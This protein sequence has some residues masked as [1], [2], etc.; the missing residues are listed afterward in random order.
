MKKFLWVAAIVGLMT[1]AAIGQTAPTGITYTNTTQTPAQLAVITTMVPTVTGSPTAPLTYTVASGSLPA[2]VALN[3]NTGYIG[4]AAMVAGTFTSTITVS[5]SAGSVTSGTIS[6]TV[7]SDGTYTSGSWSNSLLYAMNPGATGITANVANFPVLLRLNSANNSAIFSS[8]TSPNDLRFAR[9]SNTNVHYPYQIEQWNKTLQQAV[10][11]VLVDTVFSGST[12]QGITMYWGNSGAAADS[13]GKAVF[14]IGNGFAAVWHL[15]NNLTT[16]NFPG[17]SDATGN[18]Y[19]LTAHGTTH[20]DAGII[21]SAAAF[22]GASSSYLSNASVL[23]SPTVVTLSTWVAD[24]ETSGEQDFLSLDNSPTLTTTVGGGSDMFYEYSGGWYGCGSTPLTTSWTYVTAVVNPT[25]AGGG[26]A[27]E[28][29]YQ[30]G[31][32]IGT[33][34]YTAAIDYAGAATWLG[35]NEASGNTGRFLKGPMNEARVENVP[36]S[37]NWI[38]LNYINQLPAQT[39]IQPLLVPSAP[40]LS[41]PSNSAANQAVTLTL[42]WASSFGATPTSYQVQLATSSTFSTASMVADDSAITSTSQTVGSPTTLLNATYYFW[43]ALAINA[44][45]LS[46]WS[47][48]WSFSTITLWGPPPLFSPATG[49]IN[50][51]LTPTLSWVAVTNAASYEIQIST[52]PAFGSVVQDTGGIA[53]ISLTIP[54]GTGLSNY[55]TYYWRANA[56]DPNSGSDGDSPNPSNWSNA[57][58]FTTVIAVPLLSTPTNGAANQPLSS[59]GLSWGTVFNAVS[60]TLNVST[61]STFAS[62]VYN[63]SVSGTSQTL[64]N[65]LGTLQTYYWEVSATGG[66]SG[67]GPWST[68]WSFSTIPPPPGAPTIVWPENG[69]S[70]IPLSPNLTWNTVV[71]AASYEMQMATASGFSATTFDQPGITAAVYNPGPLQFLTT[72]YWEVRATNAGGS[73]PW[74]SVLSFTSCENYAANWTYS[75]NIPLT[76]LA[77]ATIGNNVT[78]FP[79]LIRFN[80]ANFPLMRTQ[81]QSGGADIRFSSGADPT[82]AYPFQ[83]D[84]WSPTNDTA[85]IWVLVDTIFAGNASHSITL[86]YGNASAPGASYGPQVFDTTNGFLGVW[87]LGVNNYSDATANGRTATPTSTITD[88]IGIIGHASKFKIPN[89]DSIKVVGLMGSP[90]MVTL[91]CWAKVDSI[92]TTSG[93][94]SDLMSIGDC[95][96][97]RVTATNATNPVGSGRD[98]AL[99]F[100]RNSAAIWPNFYQTTGV[101]TNVVYH[102]G[103]KNFAVE[104]NPSGSNPKEQV[105]LNGALV[106]TGDSAS[107]ISYSGDGV[108]TIFGRN[109]GGAK[110]FFGGVMNEP[111]IDKVIRSIDWLNLCFQNQQANQT[112]VVLAALPSIPTLASPANNA[113]GQ[114]TAL[115]LN[116]NSVSGALTYEVQV[117]TAAGFGVATVS[118][119]AGLTGVSATVAGLAGSTTYY[120]QVNATNGAGTTAWS[121]AWSFTTTIGSPALSSPANGATGQP[122]TLSL[123]WGSVSG[124]V[125]YGV[126]VST[127]MSF[128]STVSGQTGLTGLYGVVTSL[129]GGVTYYWEA[130]ATGAAATGAWSGVWSFSAG[131]TQVIP[132]NTAWNM[133]SLNVIPLQDTTTMVFGTDPGGF[134]FV[135]D[136]AGDVYCPA[137]YQDN[138]NYVQVGQG[139]QVYTTVP[140]TMEVMGIPVNYAATAIALSSGWNTIAY[141]P[142][143]DDSIEHALA[144]IDTLLI[145]V[146]N[147]SGH[148]Y[149]PSLGIDDIGIMYVGE[150]YKV[151][152]S[153]AASLTYPTPDTGVAKRVA[154]RGGKTMLRLPE[155]RHYATHANTGNN[156]TLLAK[157]VTIGD[158]AVPDSS[159]IGAFDGTGSLVGSGTV[160]HGIAAF[161]VWGIDPQGKTKKKDG[162]AVSESV[163]FRL[164]DGKREYPLDY[165]TQNGTPAKYGVDKVFLGVLSVPEGYLITKFDLTRAYPNPFRGSVKIAFDVPTIGGVTQHVIELA[166]YDLKGSLVKQLASGIY[167]AG[168][169]ALSWN[170]GEGRESAVGSSVYIVRMKAANF[171]KRMKLVRVQ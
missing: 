38:L 71:T 34:A 45:G 169:Y 122:V 87:H 164:W 161:A 127:D 7:S 84:F 147:N 112:L 89:N 63:G 44:S 64:P 116:W 86:F 55:T 15:N 130:N 155:P 73:G 171:D 119:Q 118:D 166:V 12:S 80:P 128:G 52:D 14:N 134:L 132:L 10:I 68:F 92:S 149:W 23:G 120:W 152:M 50:A 97:L 4:G 165:V 31:V 146:K 110:Y 13:S 25:G 81:V 51:A 100:Y 135:K 133:K 115:T 1:E 48:V 94:G 102:A 99:G 19:G 66:N 49:A 125:S 72:Y 139:Y 159:E 36:R 24:S 9:S 32:Q 2:G 123:S 47:A 111:R 96:A 107:L 61:A 16:G 113:T 59:V 22:A 74:S 37:A 53:A 141:L 121:A 83:I 101:G 114:P 103:W 30:N 145:I 95:A 108:S 18:G 40:T 163:T 156:A 17:L 76:T 117:A 60:Y 167:R 106:G 46:A 28:W 148:A 144:G 91:S 77:G 85:A 78:K 75:K 8:T 143:S 98:S 90:A 162:C 138:I 93:V 11:W 82:R 57:W 154:A 3:P 21:D 105:Y 109:G 6:I 42:S 69:F 29:V 153:S 67:T 140:D 27:G 88:T 170:S 124:A 39:F 62:T 168:H 129:T 157:R 35:D 160:M 150:G 136:N 137:A 58:S 20:I 158:K 131:M 43:R 33:A 142:P 70:S 104:I 79:V 56:Y 54:I 126:Q 26:A 41:S 5:N 65:T 151:L